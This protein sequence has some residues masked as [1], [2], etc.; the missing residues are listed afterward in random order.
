MRLLVADRNGDWREVA[1]VIDWC[2]ADAFWRS[3]ILSPGK[4][5]KQFTALLLKANQPSDGRPGRK[6]NA[7]DW[8]RE[9][10]QPQG[11]VA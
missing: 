6:E 9:I 11:S 7:S 1:R 3:N 5:R 10:N 2:Q 4:L 8:L